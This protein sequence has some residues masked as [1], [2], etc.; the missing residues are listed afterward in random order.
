MRVI[1]RNKKLVVLFLFIIAIALLHFHFLPSWSGAYNDSCYLSKR[2]KDNL[3]YLLTSV[4]DACKAV[5]L[6]YWIDYGTALNTK[7]TL[8]YELI[9]K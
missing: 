4:I 9:A 5:N 8:D 7:D 6:T 2:D 1:R 3:V